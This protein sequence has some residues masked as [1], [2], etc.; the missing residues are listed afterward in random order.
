MNLLLA[1]LLATVVYGL[2]TERLDRRAY[3]FVAG[4][5][6]LITA[7]FFVFQRFWV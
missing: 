5:A 2:V 7:L 3:G 1:F 6:C 4:C